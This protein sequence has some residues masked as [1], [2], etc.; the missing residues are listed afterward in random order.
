MTTPPAAHGQQTFLVRS[1][2][3]M[4]AKLHFEIDEFDQTRLTDPNSEIRSYRALNVAWTVWHIHDW[5]WEWVCDASPNT[6]VAVNTHLGTNLIAD[7]QAKSRAKR[8][9]QTKF[10]DA[11]AARYP[12]IGR[13]R[14]IATAAKHSKAESRPDP[15]LTTRGVHVLQLRAETT[16]P[17][18]PSV[19]FFDV[20]VFHD[21]E[22]VDA[23][24]VFKGAASEWG[25]FFTAVGVGY[26]KIIG[27]VAR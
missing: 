8:E 24:R 19:Q 6:S 12:N 27:N 10:A 16:L 21:R 1:W 18:E 11:I 26:P 2:Q 23:D 13:C 9:I 25:Q 4:M 5:F 7:G 17:L 22:V 20:R 14:T 3:A 15:L